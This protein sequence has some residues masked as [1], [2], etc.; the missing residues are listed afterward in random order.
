VLAH[1]TS[2]KITEWRF[3]MGCGTTVYPFTFTL[4]DLVHKVAG[5][6]V[7]RSDPG[8]RRDQPSSG[9]FWV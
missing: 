9:V 8:G 1:V 3:Q 7:P 6:Q 4:R 5:E 2:L